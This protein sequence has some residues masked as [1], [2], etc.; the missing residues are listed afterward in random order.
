MG[1]N[2]FDKQKPVQDSVLSTSIAKPEPQSGG[3]A[4]DLAGMGFDPA[5]NLKDE[6]PDIPLIKIL[7]QAQMFSMPDETK[8]VSIEGVIV[9]TYRCN[10][11]WD[12]EDTREDLR[13]NCSSL[14]DCTPLPDSPNVQSENCA[15]CKQNKF[16]SGVD[17]TG[18]PSNGKN[19]KNMRRLYVLMEGH[20]FPYMISLSPTS[21]KSA[22]K[23][24]TLLSDKH[25]HVATVITKIGL[26]K[27]TKGSNVFSIVE[28]STVKEINEPE[29]LNNILKIKKQIIEIVHSQ[30]ITKAEYNEDENVDALTQRPGDKF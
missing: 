19:C 5:E 9:E 23:Y 3:T 25:R 16:G 17:Q 28:L 8:V 10:A 30:G 15:S 11:W 13:P 27:M 2:L 21:L 20:E 14:N 1:K 7:P 24:L 22:K 4:L 6:T 29:I 18:Q 26:S 12:R